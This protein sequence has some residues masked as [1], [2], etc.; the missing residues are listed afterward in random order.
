MVF[1]N[2]WFRVK[3]SVPHTGGC[4]VAGWEAIGKWLFDSISPIVT[5]SVPNLFLLLS[6]WLIFSFLFFSF[7]AA[8]FVPYLCVLTYYSLII[9]FES[10]EGTMYSCNSFGSVTS[11]RA[12]IVI[13]VNNKEIVRACVC[14][15]GHL[16][17]LLQWTA[18]LVFFSSHFQV[19][20]ATV[21]VLYV[22]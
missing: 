16:V 14:C 22:L 20:Q 3:C 9:Q 4:A 2:H 17:D 5:P 10:G 1:L 13:N 7:K 12:D 11:R 19:K 21:P 15:L 6:W 18:N 8:S